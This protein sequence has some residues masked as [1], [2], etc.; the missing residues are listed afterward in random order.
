[1]SAGSSTS[2]TSFV[3]SI[4]AAHSVQ[5]F[6]KVE[7]GASQNAH[8]LCLFQYIHGLQ[9]QSSL[10]REGSIVWLDLVLFQ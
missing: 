8:R 6:A 2:V 5:N 9:R 1:M 10:R 7:L 3:P 4:G